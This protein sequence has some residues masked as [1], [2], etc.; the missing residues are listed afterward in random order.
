MT[1]TNKEKSDPKFHAEIGDIAVCSM[2]VDKVK[3][4]FKNMW[5]SVNLYTRNARRFQL[6]L[7]INL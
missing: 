6:V 7:L 2:I 3:V 1:I 4:F 5:R